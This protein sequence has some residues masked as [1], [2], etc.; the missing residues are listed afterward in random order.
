MKQHIQN[1]LLGTLF[2][3]SSAI[4]GQA[5]SLVRQFNGKYDFTF[6][7]NTLNPIE[8]S[9]QNIP[10]VFTS[11]SANLNL[12]PEDVIEKAYLYWAGCGTGDFDV[13]LNGQSIVADRTFSIQRIASN[14]VFDY[15][16]AFKDVTTQ[17]QATRNG[18]YTISELDVSSFINLHAQRSTN[19]AGWALIIVYKNPNLPLNQLNIYDGMQAVPDEINITLNSLNVIDTQDAKIG[20]LAWEGDSGIAVNETLRINGN[21][22]GNPPLNPVNNAFNGTNSIT[23]SS[24][25]YNMDLDIYPIQ[26]NI[27]VG[28]TSAQ[29]QL[30][31]GQDFV[32]INAI[33][34]KLNSQL[35]DA[36]VVI[37]NVTTTCDSREIT[38]DYK[39][40]NT[41]STAI[42]PINTPISIYINEI[43][44]QTIFTQTAIPIDGN[45]T[46][47][48]ILIIPNTVP[49]IFDLK[50]VVDDNGTGTGIVTEI[51]E[52]NNNFSISV[53]LSVSPLFNLLP[54]IEACNEGNSKGTFNFLDY[55]TLV[56]VNPTDS[57]RFYDSLLNAQNNINP[58]FNLSNYVAI[59]TPITIYAKLEN[60]NC[61]S[62]T[63]FVLKTKNCPPIVYNFIS[64]DNDGINDTFHIEG[65]KD[66]FLKHKIAIYNRWGTLIWTGNNSSQ[67]WDGFA[68]QGILL[69]SK[70]I[71]TGTYFYVIDL[72]DPNY[73]ESLTGHLYLT[74]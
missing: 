51:I 70:E 34:T 30:S 4:S 68:T 72:N 10:A 1:I 26:N 62:V 65:L 40:F 74:R 12:N 32:M 19:F 23:N 57:V 21:P 66:I 14:L 59:S 16:G 6:V 64:A 17:V 73:S 22:I 58:I 38:V 44:I 29:I 31:S 61:S 47:Q 36:T 3:F 25:L 39:I 15:F 28:D 33:V 43:L 53:M 52:I 37:S 2:L 67:E 20:F 69:N 9:F 54:N 7:G 27:N 8:N 11:S 56:K 13:K 45:E 5:I 55:E 48:I 35:P 24:T 49:D 63:T 18:T 46:R 60:R 71:P 42:L 41:N 50:F